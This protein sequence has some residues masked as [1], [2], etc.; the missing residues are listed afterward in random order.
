MKKRG[1]SAVRWVCAWAVSGAIAAQA[2]TGVWSN[3]SGG[4]WA[5]SANWQD[6]VVP[7]SAG[8]EPAGGD[9]ADFTALASGETV[10]L[11][12]ATSFG[13]LRFT[14]LADDVWT[15]TGSSMGSANAPDFLTERYGE[16]RVD[17]GELNLASPISNGGYGVAKTGNGSG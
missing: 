4:Y 12:N 5:D 14:G 3:V 17:E 7:S 9:V 10:T 16:I 15:I 11:T 6:G 1:G 13:A 2:A 8:S